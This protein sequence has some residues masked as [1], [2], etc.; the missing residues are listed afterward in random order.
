M[1]SNKMA[2]SEKASLYVN[3]SMVVNHAMMGY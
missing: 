3:V 1:I 2:V